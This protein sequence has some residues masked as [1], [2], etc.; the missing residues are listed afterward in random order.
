MIAQTVLALLTVMAVL[1]LLTV[2]TVFTEN[3]KEYDLL[4]LIPTHSMTT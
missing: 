4:T 3:L 1:T 2:L